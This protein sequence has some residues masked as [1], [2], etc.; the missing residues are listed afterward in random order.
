MGL[1]WL[2]SFHASTVSMSWRVWS[3]DWLLLSNKLVHEI[4]D[5]QG[6]HVLAVRANFICFTCKNHPKCVKITCKKTV[7]K[8]VR[9][10]LFLF[11][12]ALWNKVLSNLWGAKSN[13]FIIPFHLNFLSKIN[14]LKNTTC[15]WTGNIYICIWTCAGNQVPVGM[16]LL[17]YSW[18]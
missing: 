8:S 12:L 17:I 15:S 9:S 1:H 5:D 7:W 18:I 2:I 6:Y 3:C 11:L 13:R 10:F 14:R 16:H 4:V